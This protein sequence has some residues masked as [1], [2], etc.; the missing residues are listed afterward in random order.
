MIVKTGKIK[1][2]EVHLYN[3]YIVIYIVHNDFNTF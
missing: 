3:S 2:R 1:K